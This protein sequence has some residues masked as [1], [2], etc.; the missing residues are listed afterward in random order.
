MTER[1]VLSAGRSNHLEKRVMTIESVIEKRIVEIEALGCTPV[2]RKAW[3]DDV[4]YAAS[5]LEQLGTLRT[6]EIYVGILE[7]E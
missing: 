4:M 6:R 5:L 3:E 1:L 2:T 7:E